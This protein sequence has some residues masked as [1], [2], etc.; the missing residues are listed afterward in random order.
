MG[1]TLWTFRGEHEY[2]REERGERG[3]LATFFT[4]TSL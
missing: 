3:A 4:I 1:K 2:G